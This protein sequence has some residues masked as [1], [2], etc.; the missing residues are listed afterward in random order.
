MKCIG[1]DI[2]RTFIKA[3]VVENKGNIIKKEQIP[4]RGEEGKREVVLSQ[5]ENAIDFCF[6]G[7]DKKEIKG[8]GIGTPGLVDNNGIVYEAPNLPGWDNLPLREIIEKKYNIKTIV[9]ND[10]N[11]IAWGEYLFGAGKG[12]KTMICITLGTGVGGGI[13]KDGKLLRGEKYSAVEI[14]HITIDYKGQKC[15]CG[16]YGCIERYVGRDYIVERAVNAIK[17]GKETKIYELV[18]G[19]LNKITPKTISQAYN[20]GDEV[21]KDIWTDVGICLGALFSSLINP[22][23]PDIIVIGGGI[24]Q[25]GDILFET[26]RKTIKQRAMDVLAKSV[27]IVPAGLGVNAG[28][29]SGASLVFQK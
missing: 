14:G 17:E 8:I 16:N 25:A 20:L 3:G 2:G 11:T 24:S 26:I 12:C 5:I 23:N 22:L 15:K 29:I 27:E 7:E 9:E 6:K 21:A 4:T 19:N 28:I 18:G 13:V 10:V 1:I